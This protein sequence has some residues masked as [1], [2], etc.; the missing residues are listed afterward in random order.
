[1][2]SDVHEAPA[3]VDVAAVDLL[4]AALRSDGYRVVGP[5]VRQG[6]I[7]HDDITTVDDLP[8]GW[9]EHQD[10]GVYRLAR[11]PDRALFGFATGPHSWKQFLHP[12]RVLEWR[13]RRRA[14]G[15]GFTVETPVEEAAPLA[16]FGAR[17]CDLRAIAVQDRVLAG[18]EHPDPGYTARRRGIF[19]VAVNCGTPGGT[20]F[21]V[22]M[23]TGPRAQAGYDLALT[24][25]LDGERHEFLV[26][27]GTERGAALLARLPSRP[28]G[29]AD[30]SA[31]EQVEAGA[32]ESMGRTMP[33]PAEVPVLLRRNLD[34]PRWDEVAER[35]LSCGNCTMVCPTCFCTTPED[36]TDLTAQTS[37]RWRK[38][39]SCFTL[40]FSYL[41]GG[42]VRPSTRSQYRQWM[43]H[44]LSTWWDQFG[45]SGCVGCGRCITWCPVGIDLTEEVAA[46]RD[47]PPGGS[48]D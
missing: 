45:E 40:D 9:T 11:R 7:V 2:T 30:L 24:E 28:A 14:D 35:C 27:V 23:G 43:T 19:V 3:V 42:S 17:A 12:P 8:V 33:A 1:V 37:E 36:V 26:E 34:H 4:L 38:W 20:C 6:A 21:C 44:K 5:T 39:E 13:A 41:H 48:P 46:I 25:L 16:F 15:T 32:A 47:E 29:P 22:S 18:G 10:G 31:A